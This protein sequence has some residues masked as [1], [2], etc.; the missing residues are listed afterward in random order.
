MTIKDF[1]SKAIAQDDRNV[2]EPCATVDNLP[3]D[4][5]EL[6]KNANPID[7][8]LNLDGI[9]VRFFPYDELEMV[10]QEYSLPKPAFIFATSNGDPIYLMEGKIYIGLHGSSD[11]FGELF[12][13]SVEKLFDKIS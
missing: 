6:Y 3:T 11:N 2:F 9:I 7:V 5:V 12:A 1:V 4:I 8:E 10:Q 13:E